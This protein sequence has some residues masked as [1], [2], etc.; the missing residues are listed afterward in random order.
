MHLAKGIA[1]REMV[2]ELL[3]NL[4]QRDTHVV[5]YNCL[6]LDPYMVLVR[7]AKDCVAKEGLAINDMSYR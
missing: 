6:P 4:L 7:L 1:D 5:G 2:A 3:I